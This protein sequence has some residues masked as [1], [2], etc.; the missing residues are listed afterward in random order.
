MS[1]STR[2]T[3]CDILLQVLEKVI[4]DKSLEDKQRA[5]AVGLRQS[6]LKKEIVATACFFKEIFGITGPLNKYLQCINMDL[7]KANDLAYGTMSQ[8]QKLRDELDSVTNEVSNFKNTV[9]DTER[10]RSCRTR[11][12]T[13][14]DLWIRKTFYPVLD[15]MM[16]SLKVVLNRIKIYFLPCH[17][18]PQNFQTSEELAG[19]ISAFCENYSIDPTECA[20]E[21]M[22]F[23]KT[24]NK[25]KSLNQEDENGDE[26]D[27]SSDDEDD[28]DNEDDEHNNCGKSESR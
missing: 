25:L 17:G 7:G 19:V 10:M 22:S 3:I 14:E 6:F 27:D 8:L 4:A 5:V 20:Y 1:E 28:E 9:W 24:F 2:Q 13:G 23:A 18:F 26:E 11:D 15:Q 12:G 21:L 16:S